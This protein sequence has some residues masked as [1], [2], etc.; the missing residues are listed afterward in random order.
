MH[1]EPGVV[2]GAKIILS[3]ATAA[4]VLSTAG[5]LALKAVRQHGWATLTLRS[6]IAALLTFCCFELLPHPPV[7]VSE[8]HII[9]GT[10]LLLLLGPA[11]AALGLAGGLL[12]QGLVFAPIDLPQYGMNITTLLAPLFLS[13]ALARKLIPAKTAYVDLRYGQL[14]KLSLAYQGGI[15]AW[16]AFWAFYGQGVGAETLAQVATFGGAYLSIILIEPMV[17]L[18]GGCQVAS[19]LARVVTA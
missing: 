1:I 6:L 3:Y 4:T 2:D 12:L 17:D 18:A 11:A 15:V 9:L 16:V 7:G 10:T 14:L 8:V 5:W 13:A 19:A